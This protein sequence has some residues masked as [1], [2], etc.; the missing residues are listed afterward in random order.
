MGHSEMD[1]VEIHQYR[2]YHANSYDSTVSE[3]EI[4]LILFIVTIIVT[5]TLVLVMLVEVW[6]STLQI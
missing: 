3:L 5:A 6:P 1:Q 4:E 2:D